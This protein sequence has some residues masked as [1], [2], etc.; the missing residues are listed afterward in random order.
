MKEAFA[1]LY[2]IFIIILYLNGGYLRLNVLKKVAQSVS[3][4]YCFTKNNRGSFVVMMGKKGKIF[5]HISNFIVL[6][7]KNPVSKK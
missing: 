4:F 3:M 2:Y 5:P 1:K 6:M 7:L